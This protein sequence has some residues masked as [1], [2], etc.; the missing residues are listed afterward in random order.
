MGLSLYEQETVITF[1]RES[2][3][4]TVYTANPYTMARLS[5][6]PAYTRVEE[7]KAGGEVVAMTFKADKKLLTLR[8][9]R[10]NQV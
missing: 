6:L 9:K 10:K 5:K 2:D 8:T 4:M 1:N 3:D 7:D